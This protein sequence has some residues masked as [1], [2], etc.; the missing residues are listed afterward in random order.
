MCILTRSTTSRFNESGRRATERGRE[1]EREKRREGERKRKGKGKREREKENIHI[2]GI[3]NQTAARLKYVS[4]N[5]SYAGYSFFLLLLLPYTVE[6][7]SSSCVFCAEKTVRE[8]GGRMGMRR[9]RR[10]KRGEWEIIGCPTSL[11]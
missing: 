2:Q 1:K 7:S 8:R 5:F 6:G 4:F 9:R 10:E 11:T 3:K